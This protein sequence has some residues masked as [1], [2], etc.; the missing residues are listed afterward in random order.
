MPEKRTVEV[1][2][3]QIERKESPR[4]KSII[5]FNAIDNF[6]N[7]VRNFTQIIDE[8]GVDDNQKRV[9]N[10]LKNPEG[11]SILYMNESKGFISGIISSGSY[12]KE[13]SVVD[14][15][16][17]ETEVFSIKKNHAVKKP[18]YFLICISPLKDTGFIIMERQGSN[19]INSLISFFMYKLIS[20]KYPNNK[21]IIRNFIEDDVAKKYV[22]DGKYKEVALIR[23]FLPADVADR[24]D[25]GNFDTS[26]YTIKLSIKPNKNKTFP[27]ATKNKL[28]KILESKQIGFFT[29]EQF[30]EL[31]FDDNSKIQVVSQFNGRQRT[32]NLSG[33]MK[34]RPYYEIEVNVDASGNTNYHSI[35]SECI[36][37]L[38]SFGLE[39][40]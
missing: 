38:N 14:V 25:L 8:F 28:V 33:S 31:G 26:D 20:E 2:Q 24:Y 17:I 15:E 12:G 10:I 4:R 6:Q 9:A 19:S 35:H 27:I 37:L 36:Q 3:F 30:E 29:S 7:I 34:I 18:F 22:A 1:H 39:L 32:V 21:I 13:E 16:D 40:F 11:E 23:S 5:H